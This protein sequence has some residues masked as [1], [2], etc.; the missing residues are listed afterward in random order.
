MA[1]PERMKAARVSRVGGPEVLEIAEVPL[2]PR[3]PKQVL[4]KV[5]ATS[6]NPIDL[7]C[8]EGSAFSYLQPGNKV[9]Q[10]FLDGDMPIC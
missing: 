1:M 6:I 8:R 7:K 4:V 2:P 10:I 9:I 5:V 3:G